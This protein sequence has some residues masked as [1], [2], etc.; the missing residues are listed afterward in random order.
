MLILRSSLTLN[1]QVKMAFNDGTNG[2]LSEESPELKEYQEWKKA[3]DWARETSEWEDSQEMKWEDF[4]E[5][6]E[7]L[8][9]MEE[10]ILMDEVR[11]WDEKRW[12]EYIISQPFE[13]IVQIIQPMDH[14]SRM[15]YALNHFYPQGTAGPK[16]IAEIENLIV[17]TFGDDAPVPHLVAPHQVVSRF[18]A[19][20]R[21]QVMPHPQVAFC[22]QVSTRP[23]KNRGPCRFGTRCTNFASGM[24]RFEHQ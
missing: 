21:F 10:S 18:Q 20:P 17:R 19:D 11:D 16:E 5:G 13:V 4:P 23:R 15:I 1:T 3:M 12:F 2:Y 24:C 22:P 14:H 8:A 9:W 6:K 7:A